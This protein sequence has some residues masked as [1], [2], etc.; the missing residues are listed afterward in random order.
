M[1]IKRTLTIFMATLM[2]AFGMWAQSP[3]EKPVKWRMTVKM[4]SETDGVVTLRAIVGN[5]WHV[6]G[7]NLPEEGPIP[8]TF[9]F[10]ASTGIEF[11]T[12]DFVPS[13]EPVVKTDKTFGITLNWWE[14]NV[15]FTRNFRLIG[16][17]SKATVSGK[18]RYMCCNDQ[19]CTP[20]TTET[21]TATVRPFVNK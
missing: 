16:D 12:P 19:T 4:T 5:G 18:V 7:T 10:D 6:Y 14:S 17:L 2:L 21:F 8:T 13:I 9:D 3:A 15:S 11:T 20:P 1:N